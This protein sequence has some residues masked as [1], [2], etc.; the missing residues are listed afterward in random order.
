MKNSITIL[1]LSLTLVFLSCEAEDINE[2]NRM[3]Q[4]EMEKAFQQNYNNF[5]DES[6]PKMEGRWKVSEINTL[7]L[8]SLKVDSVLYNIGEIELKFT[9]IS[10]ENKRLKDYYLDGIFHINNLSIPFYSSYISATYEANLCHVTVSSND[11]SPFVDQT[12]PVE[13]KNTYNFIYDHFINMNYDLELVNNGANLIL[14]G[15]SKNN[16]KIILTKIQ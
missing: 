1:L 15:T 7:E 2:K 13:D 14:T 4:A 9:D 10:H 16:K 3:H 6:V 11:L 12:L 8:N 5:L